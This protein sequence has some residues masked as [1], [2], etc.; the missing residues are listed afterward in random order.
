MR[1][2]RLHRVEPKITSGVAYF[3]MTLAGYNSFCSV[4][5]W[6]FLF[7]IRNRLA[8]RHTIL[9]IQFLEKEREREKKKSL[10]MRHDLCFIHCSPV[11]H[12]YMYSL[13]RMYVFVLW[14][15]AAPAIWPHACSLSSCVLF[16]IF[17]TFSHTLS[18]YLPNNVKHPK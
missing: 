2:F 11:T 8:A 15:Q 5:L 1:F 17:C 14:Q 10:G 16:F 12:I 6:V 3:M 18:K 13:V 7:L 9:C 4:H